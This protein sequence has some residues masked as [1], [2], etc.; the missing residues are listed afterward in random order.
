MSDDEKR[1]PHCAETIKAAAIKC[2]FC[3]EKLEA[4]LDPFRPV[5]KPAPGQEVYLMPGLC[6]AGGALLFFYALTMD[7]SVS[8]AF[9]AVSNLSLMNQQA[10]LK[11]AGGFISVLGMFWAALARGK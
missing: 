5:E 2:R 1:C 6:I 10:N 4:R 9:G 11:M 7:T 3:G 8:T